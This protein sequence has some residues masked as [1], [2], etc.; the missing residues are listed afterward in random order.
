MAQQPLE[1]LPTAEL[2]EAARKIAEVLDPL[3]PAMRRQLL[4]K[5]LRRLGHSADEVSRMLG[6]MK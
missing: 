1:T 4:A 3:T 5:A 6:K 2:R